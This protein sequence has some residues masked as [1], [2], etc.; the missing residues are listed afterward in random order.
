MMVFT[1]KIQPSNLPKK[2]LICNVI[3]PAIFRLNTRYFCCNQSDLLCILT[4]L[5]SSEDIRC[6]FEC[7]MI[8][9]EIIG[10][11]TLTIN[12]DLD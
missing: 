12:R 10:N 2:H 8:S 7:R 4:V 5:A 3:E 1:H 11:R 6:T 9:G